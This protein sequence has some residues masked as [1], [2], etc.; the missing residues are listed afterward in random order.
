MLGGDSILSET[1]YQTGELAARHFA[2]IQHIRITASLAQPTPFHQMFNGFARRGRL[3]MLFTQNIDGLETRLS[4]LRTERPLRLEGGGSVNTLE[5]HG[6]ANFMYCSKCS[7]LDTIQLDLFYG[8]TLPSCPECVMNSER[9]AKTPNPKRTRNPGWL[10]PWVLLYYHG[11]R[12]L[13]AD[14]I[15]SVIKD[16]IAQVKQSTKEDPAPPPPCLIVG[17]TRLNVP[18]AESALKRL[19]T[20]VREAKGEVI[21]ISTTTIK[22]ELEPFFT[23]ILKG[24]CDQLAKEAGY[25]V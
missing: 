7:F 23:I 21:W 5:L 18:G 12:D 8:E 25:T 13:Q 14:A 2:F 3:L 11:D 17:G 16:V 1:L 6:N 19:S 15:S 22:K 24:T 10:K 9:E 20:A 4:H